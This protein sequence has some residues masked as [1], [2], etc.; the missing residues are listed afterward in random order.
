MPWIAPLVTAGAGLAG[1]IYSSNK[2]ADAAEAANSGDLPDWLRPYIK[3]AGPI[4]S[5]L[6]E[7]PKIN[8]GWLEYIQQLGRGDPNANWQPMT[9]DSPFFN[10]DQTFTPGPADAQNP[11]GA[12]PPGM[13]QPPP[14]QQTP[15]Q[16]QQPPGRTAEQIVADINRRQQERYEA[17]STH[18]FVPPFTRG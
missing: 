4:P 3:G 2:A 13:N 11:Y 18:G 6:T 14:G 1:S 8:T 12:L 5:Y 9:A 17:L 10:P 15:Q 16:P 7:T